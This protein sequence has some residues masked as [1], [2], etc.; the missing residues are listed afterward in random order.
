MHLGMPKF[1]SAVAI[2]GTE[3]AAR[4]LAALKKGYRVGGP[5]CHLHSSRLSTSHTFWHPQHQSAVQVRDDPE[6]QNRVIDV[7][8]MMNGFSLKFV[9]PGVQA[10]GAD[11]S[12]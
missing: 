4:S 7:T 6:H 10:G 11:P 12:Q 5:E 1:S 8:S 2:L 9:A 3:R